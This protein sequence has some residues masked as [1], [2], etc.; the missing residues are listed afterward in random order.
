M[1]DYMFLM[2]DD[3]AANE[4]LD[5]NGYIGRL[6]ALGVFRG[7]S[8][9]GDGILARKG[10]GAESTELAHM[11]GFIRVEA[12][13]LTHARTLLEGNPTYEAGGTVEVRELPRDG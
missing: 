7:G 8:S 5:W 4:S 12:D 13:D 3:A 6:S 9:I 10:K 1:A 2:H 11:V